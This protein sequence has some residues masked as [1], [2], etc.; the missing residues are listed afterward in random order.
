MV[1]LI[2]SGHQE[3]FKKLMS[4]DPGRLSMISGHIDT[5][6]TNL[7]RSQTMVKR[8]TLF[9]DEKIIMSYLAPGKV[10]TSKWNPLIYC[11][12][13]QNKDLFKYLCELPD[14]NLRYCLMQ[15]FRTKSSN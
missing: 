7:M 3:E 1:S 9:K 4:S 6:T 10:S 8:I 13:L 12:V 14:I 5:D 15:P 2:K 11:L